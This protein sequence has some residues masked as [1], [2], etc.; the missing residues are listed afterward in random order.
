M[1]G[2]VYALDAATLH[3]ETI[4]GD[5]WSAHDVNIALALLPGSS[6][7]VRIARLEAATLPE[8]IDNVHIECAALELTE[9]RI[10]C[11]DGEL[12]ARVPGLTLTRQPVQFVYTHSD[13]GIQLELHGLRIGSGGMSLMGSLVG[14]R[15]NV[16]TAFER[17]PLADLLRVAAL[18]Q[19]PV[20]GL[21]AD[22]FL[23]GTARAHGVDAA[24][25]QV[26]FAIEVGHL[27][28]NNEAGTLATDQLTLGVAGK[29]AQATDGLQFEVSVDSQLGQAYME[30]VFLDFGVHGLTLQVSGRWLDEHVQL[31]AFEVRHR[32]VLEARGAAALDLSAEMPLRALTLELQR[33]QL[34]SAYASYMQPFLLG[35]GFKSLETAGSIDGQVTMAAGAPQR[36]DLNFSDVTIEDPEQ[37]FGIAALRGTWH[38]RERAEITA[39][40][41]ERSASPA[42]LPSRISWDSGVL[43]GLSLGATQLSFSTEGR[44]VRLLQ[45]ASIPI[46]D[47]A[48]HLETFRIRNAGLPSVAFLIDAALQPI[49][50]EQ[51]CRVFGWPEFGGQIGGTIS[52]LR[53][54]EGVV[55]LGTT[56]EAEVFDGH[57]AIRDLRLEQPFGQWPRFS[58][59]IALEK[60]DLEL[61][62]RAFSFGRITGR[63][64]GAIDG[65]EL[66][67]WTP[68]AFDARLFTPPDDRSRRRISQ[69][70]VENIGS[71]GGASGG[72]TA[73]LSSGVMKFFDDFNYDRLGISCR[74]ENEV[75]HMNGVLP[76]SNGGYYLVKGRGLPRIDVI[77]NAHRVDWPRLV[78]QLIAITESGA[79][80]V[81]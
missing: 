20:V 18:W 56:L 55:T 60:L 79:P 64:S 57:V 22:G 11:R 47:G 42:P 67:N 32:D 21:S 24:L 75:C 31:D 49:S 6:A 4:A 51:L 77:G 8:A 5:S 19:L 28:A 59:A 78:Q 73:A 16:E 46:L 80:V 69:R 71:M 62:T 23:S 74:L 45:P 3:I 15:W 17:T 65:L 70:A 10:A 44:Q 14:D 50:V 53:M 25:A 27:T 72:V 7:Q 36:I 68:V 34:P 48:L 66:F 81:R 12:T 29:I 2:A 38:W 35:T 26:S 54:R 76:A 33:L 40:Q 41:G 58:A 63:L 9:E 43:L 39:V 37:S 1:M 61:V 30:P 13:A 52:K